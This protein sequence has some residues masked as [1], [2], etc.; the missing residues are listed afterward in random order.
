LALE[1]LLA[2]IAG[3]RSYFVD[4]TDTKLLSTHLQMNIPSVSSMVNSQVPRFFRFT[5]LFDGR[6]QP[7][8]ILFSRIVPVAL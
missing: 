3:S 2:G 5:V 1:Y 4:A 6:G 8:G 7:R